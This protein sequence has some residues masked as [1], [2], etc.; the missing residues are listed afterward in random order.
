MEEKDFIS[1]MEKLK[2]PEISSD[3]AQRQ[4]KL[5]L[6]NTK[7][8]AVW[9]TWFLVVP[10]FFFICVTIKYLF[11]WNWGV[12]GNFLDWM[13][14]LD[15]ST[16]FPFISILLFIILPGIGAIVNLLAVM[17]FAY[18]KLTSELIVTIKLKWLNIILAIIS[19]GI[20]GIIFL[21]VLTENA[22]EKGIKKY[23]TEKNYDKIYRN[24]SMKLHKSI[25]TD[26]DIIHLLIFIKSSTPLIKVNGCMG[27]PG[28]YKSIL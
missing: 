14:N 4:I 26:E 5:T 27:L 15:K 25:P 18:D 7:K 12:A 23:D 21:Y 22:M 16:V 3:A 17:H 9:G 20:V 8:S 24:Q 1:K 28:T 2:K 10:I 13:A 11:R 19:I 6:L